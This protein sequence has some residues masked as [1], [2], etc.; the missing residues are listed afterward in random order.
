[1]C[2]IMEVTAKEIVG[3]AILTHHEG[4]ELHSVANT[5]QRR[6]NGKD[7]VKHKRLPVVHIMVNLKPRKGAK[8]DCYNS[9]EI[10]NFE[11]GQ[12]TTDGAGSSVCL[13]VKLEIGSVVV[14]Q[15]LES[16][17]LVIV[18]QEPVNFAV[19]AC[20]EKE[21]NCPECD[22]ESI[23]MNATVQEPK[24]HTRHSHS[25]ATLCIDK[26]TLKRHRK[27]VIGN[28]VDVI[29]SSIPNAAFK[30]IGKWKTS[31]VQ[32]KGISISVVC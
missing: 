20:P 26:S 15:G 4:D 28:G 30:Y 18:E 29:H 21:I 31:S 19:V 12:R 27:T 16:G 22:T 1:M 13:V 2:Q 32:S 25:E 3:Y 11:H 5:V 10:E 24:A 14:E 8:P 9:K 23:V 6:L 7:V 17:D